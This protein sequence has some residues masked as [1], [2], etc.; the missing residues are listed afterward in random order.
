VKRSTDDDWVKRVVNRR[1]PPNKF[2][3]ALIAFDDRS[4]LMPAGSYV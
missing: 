4:A 2:G 3:R 1:E